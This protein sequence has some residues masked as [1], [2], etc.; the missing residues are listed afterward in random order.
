MPRRAIH[1]SAGAVASVVIA[2]YI[3]RDQPQQ[4]QIIEVLAAGFSGWYASLLPDMIDPPTSGNH[5]GVGHGAVQVCAGILAALQKTPEA[6]QHLRARAE[7]FSVRLRRVE[8][9]FKDP[10]PAW[11]LAAAELYCRML[12]GA[13][14]GLAVGVGLHLLLDARTPRGLPL[15]A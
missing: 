8:L 10:W 4:Q 9:G 2:S 13:L 3:A 5:R 14:I 12:A 15:I 1:Q 11:Q 7:E 6:Q